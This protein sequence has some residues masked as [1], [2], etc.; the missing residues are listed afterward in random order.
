MLLL[1]FFHGA[2]RLWEW[3]VQ[4][5]PA[6]E[7]HRAPE[8]SNHGFLFM[9]K[10]GTARQ[11]GCG[12]RDIVCIARL[13][14]IRDLEGAIAR[15]HERSRERDRDALFAPGRDVLYRA[16][17]TGGMPLPGGRGLCLRVP[18]SEDP[19]QRPSAFD[20]RVRTACDIYNRSITWAFASPIERARRAFR[21]VSRCRSAASTSRTIRRA[22]TGA[23]RRYR[24]P[25]ADELGIDGLSIR[26]RGRDRR[27]ARGR[28]HAKAPPR[29]QLERA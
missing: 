7:P 15:L 10:L 25:P 27:V 2:S 16:E 12:H 1:W 14:S 6:T 5:M 18:L 24:F 13:R 26:Y 22:R 9:K 19:R 23:I 20:P 21:R 29:F 3:L 28:R 11:F 17:D 4:R 8:T